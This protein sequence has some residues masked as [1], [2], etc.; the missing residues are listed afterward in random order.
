MAAACLLLDTMSPDASTSV[1]SKLRQHPLPQS[2]IFEGNGAAA[3]ALV[4]QHR[5]EAS[6]Q[7]PWQLKLWEDKK[8]CRREKPTRAGVATDR[9]IQLRWKSLVTN[10]PT[11]QPTNLPTTQAPDH[12]ITHPPTNQTTNLPTNQPTNPPPTTRPPYHQPTNLP[13]H[14]SNRPPTNQPANQATHRHTNEPTNQ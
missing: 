1:P 4:Q 3:A 10:Q 6:R 5:H 12:H 8:Q 13:N 7:L 14:P 9:F 2:P 11:Y